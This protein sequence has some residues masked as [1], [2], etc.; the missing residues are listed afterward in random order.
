MRQLSKNY[1]SK[2]LARSVG[3]DGG[4]CE[5]A[6]NA[7]CEVKI[8][9]DLA[10]YTDSKL[11]LYESKTRYGGPRVR[12]EHLDVHTHPRFGRRIGTEMVRKSSR[13]AAKPQN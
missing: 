1:H 8:E 6:L 2:I 13:K 11:E 3:V 4:T 9:R 5:K 12:H 7:K 10:V